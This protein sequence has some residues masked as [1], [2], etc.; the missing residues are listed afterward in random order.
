MR[1]FYSAIIFLFF[2]SSSAQLTLTNLADNSSISDGDVFTY[3][4]TATLDPSDL[5][6][7]LKFRISNASTTESIRVL[8]EIVAFTNTD[9]T[10]S[11]YCIQPSC[12]FDMSLGQTIPNSP[13]ELAPGEDNGD[14]DSFYNSNPG[15]GVNYP[16][17]YT[18][19]FYMV[20]NNDQEVGDD[21]TITYSYTPENFSTSSFTLEDLGIVL[22]NTFVSETLNFDANNEISFR[23]F[24]INGREIDFYEANIGQHQ[25]NMGHLST[26]YYLISFRDNTG[27]QTQTRIQKK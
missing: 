25:Y 18:L 6:G 24:D 13:L 21:I 17:T 3:D 11:Q 16:L 19:R 27:K 1:Y 9:G 26:G 23:L 20:D 15:D 2:F 8:G 12:F 5:D 7:K 4:K 14:F 22:H 10:G